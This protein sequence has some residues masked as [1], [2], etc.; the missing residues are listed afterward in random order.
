MNNIIGAVN[1]ALISME[2]IMKK[3]FEKSANPPK[4]Q[5]VDKY[6]YSLKR[7]MKENGWHAKR[8]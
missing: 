8:F 1:P 4:P 2:I 3:E 7:L 6:R 5:E